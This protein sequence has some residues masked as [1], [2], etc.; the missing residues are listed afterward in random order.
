MAW[1]SCCRRCGARGLRRGRGR[2]GGAGTRAHGAAG[3]GGNPC[4]LEGYACPVEEVTRTGRPAVVLHDHYDRAGQVQHIEVQAYAMF[5]EQGR[6]TRVIEYTCDVWASRVVTSRAQDKGSGLVVHTAPRR[7]APRWPDPG[8]QRKREERRL[9]SRSTFSS[10]HTHP[11][12]RQTSFG[13]QSFCPIASET[14]APVSPPCGLR[15]RRGSLKSAVQPNAGLSE[16]AGRSPLG[17]TCGRM[18]VRVRRPA[19]NTENPW[20]LVGDPR[21]TPS[22]YHSPNTAS[23]SGKC[24]SPGC[25]IASIN[26]SAE[27]CDS[28]NT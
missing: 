24:R 17:E 14:E 27:S 12:S 3:P 28:P 21:T 8:A 11:R 10:G 22:D 1:A 25:K 5:D 16:L 23:R 6:V 26:S 19:H 13:R 7:R 9:T 2:G 20:A 15:V 18:P 4:K